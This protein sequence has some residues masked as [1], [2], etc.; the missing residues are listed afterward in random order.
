MCNVASTYEATQ[1]P[2]CPLSTSLGDDIGH[3]NPTP[4]RSAV[5]SHATYATSTNYRSRIAT[6]PLTDMW[7]GNPH[8]GPHVSNRSPSHRHKIS[9]SPF[10]FIF[11]RLLPLHCFFSQALFDSHVLTST[12]Q[13][14]ETGG[15]D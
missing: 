2:L 7:A 1:L 3:K 11:P 4:Y 13:Q 8:P 14:L 10:R 6:N 12:T 9:S 15:G 5:P